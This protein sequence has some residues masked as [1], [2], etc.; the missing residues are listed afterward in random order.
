M[1][2][3]NCPTRAPTAISEILLEQK[4]QNGFVVVPLRLV[5]IRK[6]GIREGQARLV[7]E[8]KH[9]LEEAPE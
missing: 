3:T 7:R 6:Q 8:R 9:D 2:P 4:G 1:S 5:D